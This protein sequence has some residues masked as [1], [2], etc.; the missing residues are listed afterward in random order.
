MYAQPRALTDELVAKAAL[1]LN[2]HLPL[3]VPASWL[4][5]VL[6]IE[7]LRRLHAETLMRASGEQMFGPLLE[8]LGV[9]VDVTQADLARIPRQGPVVITANHPFGLLEGPILGQLL[10]RIRPDVRFLANSLL[11]GL[12]KFGEYVIPVD[13]FGGPEAAA[14]NRGPLRECLNWLQSGGLLV[15]LPAG[16]VSSFQF[17]RM[18]VEDRAW[19][20]A[21]VRLA[22]IAKAAVVP[23]YIHGSNGLG[24]QTAGLVHPQARTALLVRELLN[25]KGQTARI[26]IGT[27]LSPARLSAFQTDQDATEYLRRRVHLLR[28]RSPGRLNPG[29]AGPNVQIPVSGPVEPHSMQE[30]VRAL[31][32]NQRLARA[33]RLSVFAADA[34]QIP[35]VLREIGRLREITFRLAG[36]GTGREIDLDRYDAHY[37]HLFVWNDESCEIVGAYRAA[38][39]SDVIERHGVKG[40]YT[41]SLFHINPALFARIGPSMELGRSFVRPEYQKQAM[42]LFLLWNG[43][44]RLVALRPECRHLFGPVSISGDYSCASREMVVTYLKERFL[45]RPLGSLVRSRNGFRVRPLHAGEFRRI[46]K[47]LNGVEEL[48]EVVSDMDSQGRPVPVLV[49]Q[50]MNLGARFL[51][52]NVDKAFSGVV[53]GL[54]LVDLLETNSKLRC[55]YLG[56][57]GE[58]EFLRLHL[59]GTQTPRLDRLAAS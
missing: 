6:M 3:P 25:K 1:E 39:T 30:E 10:L 42:P 44:G 7:D 33:G 8:A 2:R 56:A 20:P 24:F 49:R 50:Y 17:G 21:A 11:R 51:G 13:P 45:D 26:T 40:L 55:K 19:N 36:E 28:W 58:Q 16:E 38:Y 22:K 31:P 34:C 9:R 54:V 52:F 41:H 47:L 37:R 46:A 14:R 23:M 18:R 12:P 29:A 15:V 59:D 48:S 27:P 5:R 35:L 4:G 57:A 53:D 43:I 32:E